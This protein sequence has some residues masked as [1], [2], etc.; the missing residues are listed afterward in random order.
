MK[1]IALITFLLYSSIYAKSIDQKI[2]NMFVVGFYGTKASKNS[3]IVQDIC[4]R[5][6]GGVLLF[7]RHPTRHS[8]AKNIS[9]FSQLKSLAKSLSSACK[10]QPLIAVD[11]EGGKVQRLRRK[12]GFYGRYPKASMLATQSMDVAKKAYINMADELHSVGIN[13]NLAPVADMAVNKKNRVIYKLGRSY[14]VRA[15]RVALF[16]KIFINAMHSRGILTSI[17]HFPGHG[18]SLG[19]THKG[20]VDVTKT[21][22]KKELEPFSELVDSGKL[23][24]VMVAH[25]FNKNIDSRYPASLSRKTIHGL[26]RG[27]L[28]YGGVVITD[29]LQ[30]Y[31]I[32]KHYSL[33]NTIKLA[34]NAGVDILLF[35]NQ[36]DPK[37]EITVKKL[38]SITQSLLSKGEISKKS[39]DRA[40]H[41]ID[42]MKRK[43]GLRI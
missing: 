35:G 18:S 33:R 1:K 6:L 10:H 22:S 43:I 12:D 3:K 26:L 40:N 9:S 31:A 23:D 5:G 4:S 41:R 13:F 29:D 34:I 42:S 28:G 36:L 25:V 14:G 19:D 24:S 8:Q 37:H 39:I 2:A 27:K 30:M 11:Q 32:S 7:D 16:N 17:K 38:V 21:W 20:F 15:D